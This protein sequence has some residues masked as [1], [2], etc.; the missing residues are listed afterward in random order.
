MR[1]KKPCQNPADSKICKKCNVEKI[2]WKNYRY[3]SERDQYHTI[4]TECLLLPRKTKEWRRKIWIYK[5]KRTENASQE[6]LYKMKIAKDYW[7]K[8]NP[9]YKR[10]MD[11]SKIFLD[12]CNKRWFYIKEMWWERD[13]TI[14]AGTFDRLI[15]KQRWRCAISRLRLVN[16]NWD[17]HYEIDHIIPVWEWW[18]HSESNIQLLLPS[19]HRIKTNKEI[20]RRSKLKTN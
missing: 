6:S 20:T 8:K 16:E 15:N 2:I 3:R 14:N 13:N 11:D 1:T 12:R 9:H 18:I 7:R 10:A 17:L 4:C 5:K 19:V